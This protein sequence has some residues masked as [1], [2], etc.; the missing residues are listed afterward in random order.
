[1]KN[2]HDI[3]FT[4]EERKI[5]DRV[6]VENEDYA[7][8]AV[9]EHRNETDIDYDED[10]EIITI[11]NG[12]VEIQQTVGMITDVAETSDPI[13]RIGVGVSML[14]VAAQMEERFLLDKDDY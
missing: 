7:I 10:E 1:M 2:L 13:E 3:E 9:F 5:I 8:C 4:E 14:E 6:G 11:E 12:D